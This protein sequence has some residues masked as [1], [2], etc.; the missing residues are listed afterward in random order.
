M[1]LE[2]RNEFRNPS[3]LNLCQLSID[4]K[5]RPSTTYNY[6]LNVNTLMITMFERSRIHKY[7]GLD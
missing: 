5:Y 1:K 2:R 4:S 3:R 7:F 6:K